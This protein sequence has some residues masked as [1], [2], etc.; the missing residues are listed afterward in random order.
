MPIPEKM[1]EKTYKSFN[2]PPETEKAHRKKWVGWATTSLAT[3]A[4]AAGAWQYFSSRPDLN[5]QNENL[6][7]EY[8][9]QQTV[10][11]EAFPLTL[12]Q[13]LE[14]EK[15]SETD[16]LLPELIY[17]SPKESDPSDWQ[18]VVIYSTAIG[19]TQDPKALKNEEGKPN[20]WCA[21]CNALATE[22][23]FERIKEGLSTRPNTGLV[24]ILHPPSRTR[25]SYFEIPNHAGV[26]GT[27]VYENQD[28]KLTEIA[29]VQSPT[30]KAHASETLKTLDLIHEGKHQGIV[31]TQEDFKNLEVKYETSPDALADHLA[32]AEAKALFPERVSEDYTITLDLSDPEQ[33]RFALNTNASNSLMQDQGRNILPDI[34]SRIIKYGVKAQQ[35][36]QDLKTQGAKVDNLL[37]VRSETP[38]SENYPARHAEAFEEFFKF[39]QQFV[40]PYI[41]PFYEAF[42]SASQSQFLGQ[43]D[44]YTIITDLNS[45]EVIETFETWAE[46][47]NRKLT[48]RT[49]KP[50]E[51]EN[52]ARSL[53]RTQNALKFLRERN[54]GYTPSTPKP[55]LEELTQSTPYAVVHISRAPFAENIREIEAYQEDPSL[56][57]KSKFSL[58]TFL[59]VADQLKD[60]EDVTLLSLPYVPTRLGF[61]EAPNSSVTRFGDG[62]AGDPDTAALYVLKNGDYFYTPFVG[63][64]SAEEAVEKIK[65]KISEK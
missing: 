53:E 63:V 12:D 16:S 62:Y 1:E 60:R 54:I 11:G 61:T 32:I 19:N 47:N 48:K 27:R 4:L 49:F 10:K 56:D 24:K 34:S 3:L 5:K 7:T 39:S 17:T 45:P 35:K 29:T 15:T 25:P 51:N 46:E 14:N 43:A 31:L 2:S 8:R 65:E 42:I 33:F 41:E 13:V 20:T 22:N 26:P 38:D 55:V 37:S 18:H 64:P 52:V 6:P 59:A 50:A 57:R 30:A 23:T 21:P 9:T 44:D 28:G 36:N 58:H 40:P